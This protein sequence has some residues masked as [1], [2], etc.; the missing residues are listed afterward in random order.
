MRRRLQ[1]DRERDIRSQQAFLST[2]IK[3][4]QET[5][6]NRQQQLK[7]L[8]SHITE[9][10]ALLTTQQETTKKFRDSG[11]DLFS[12]TEDISRS[13]ADESATQERI[14]KYR[15]EME[16]LN[17]EIAE[18]TKRN[19]AAREASLETTTELGEEE[20]KG[21]EKEEAAL[22]GHAARMKEL[23]DRLEAVQVTA[24]KRIFATR[25]EIVDLE[26]DFEDKLILIR[27]ARATAQL[28]AQRERLQAQLAVNQKAVNEGK[29]DVG[30]FAVIK[31]EIEELSRQIE[32]INNRT[33][34]ELDASQKARGKA[35]EKA[36]PLSTRSLF[37]DDF[38]NNLATV[39]ENL[40]KTGKEMSDLKQNAMAL[41]MTAADTFAK[42]SEAAGNFGTM[43]FD[44]FENMSK[45]I[46]QNVSQWVL[47][48]EA[49]PNAL[50]KMTAQVLANLAQQAIVKSLFEL[51]EGFALL[52]IG[53]E[54]GAS[55]AF[56]SSGI[57]AAVA[58]V[59]AVSGRAFAGDLFKNQS[60][61]S[62]K[63]IAGAGQAQGLGS[64]N[65]QPRTITENRL[66]G[67]PLPPVVTKV[68]EVQHTYEI[69]PP[70]GWVVNE[71]HENYTGNGRVRQMIRNEIDA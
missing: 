32:A 64:S 18:S 36:S 52:A 65:N 12:N 45:A 39:R 67:A 53:D 24:G 59:A 31:G 26:F 51:A 40:K 1:S 17:S 41:G 58:A 54:D 23:N 6:E 62:S 10:E 38:A 71:I 48:G 7:D 61:S 49:G 9:E 8:A 19:K 66:Q 35:K 11:S 63:S 22:A 25:K 20:R 13:K 33:G 30:S 15:Q 2:E 28:R 44:M 56:T 16:T 68:I 70:Q 57:Y 21:R 60:A 27:G 42:M 37:G 47:Y 14:R 4:T 43:A 3:S 50:R 5:I 34:A 46:G 29:A 55:D 69:K